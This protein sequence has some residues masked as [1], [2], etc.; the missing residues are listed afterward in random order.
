VWNTKSQTRGEKHGDMLRGG[1]SKLGACESYAKNG[2]NK[3][4]LTD[5]APKKAGKIP[6][7]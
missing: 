1:R 4:K 3:R 2:K 6:D 7:S 5:D